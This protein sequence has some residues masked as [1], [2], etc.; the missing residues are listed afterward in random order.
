M[1]ENMKRVTS[2]TLPELLNS[3]AKTVL[4]FGAPTGRL[5]MAQADAF[6]EAWADHH[7]EAAFAYVDALTDAELTQTYGVRR[8][9]TILVMNGPGVAARLEGLC[10]PARIGAAL[11]PASEVRAA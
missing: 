6:A 9:P 8:L 10:S 1:E 3:E 5:M 4:L 2:E 7:D 11:M